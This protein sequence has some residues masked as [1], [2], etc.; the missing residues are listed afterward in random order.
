MKTVLVLLIIV[1]VGI[2]GVLL[3]MVVDCA[4]SLDHSR[5]QNQALHRKCELLARLADDG[6]RGRPPSSV[7]R[8]AG[9]NVIAK[10]EGEELRLDD[11]VLHIADERIA[12]LDM[13]ETCR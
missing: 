2:T 1:L 9:S 8:V 4:I 13:M 12:R 7:I 3:Y 5:V 10:I 6:L 11:V